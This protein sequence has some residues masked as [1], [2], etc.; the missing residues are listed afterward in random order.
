MRKGCAVNL[1]Q[2]SDRNVTNFIVT[3][4]HKRTRKTPFSGQCDRLNQDFHLRAN[5]ALPSA[6]PLPLK[7]ACPPNFSSFTILKTGGW[8]GG[9]RGRPAPP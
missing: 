7:Q 8:L 6:L 2:S 9:G 3:K 1:N 5:P 4:T